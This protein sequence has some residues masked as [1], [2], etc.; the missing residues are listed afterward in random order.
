VASY[1]DYC[2]VVFEKAKKWLSG[3]LTTKRKEG[4]QKL[5]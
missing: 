4:R 5:E 3:P 2:I 1:K